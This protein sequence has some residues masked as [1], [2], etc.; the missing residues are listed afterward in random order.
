MLNKMNP[1]FSVC[2]EGTQVTGD[3]KMSLEPDRAGLLS[4]HPFVFRLV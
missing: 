1:T 3:S 4:P 2:L